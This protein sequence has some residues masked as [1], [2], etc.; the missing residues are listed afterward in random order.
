VLD[1]GDC[2]EVPTTVVD[3]TGPEPPV[4]LRRGGGDPGRFE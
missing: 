3:F 2:G 4:V 1:S